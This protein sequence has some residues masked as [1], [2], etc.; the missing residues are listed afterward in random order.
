MVRDEI[1]ASRHLLEALRVDAVVA[2]QRLDVRDARLLVPGR[3][4]RVEPDQ[5]AEKV[6]GVDH[7]F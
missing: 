3:V 2:E 6:D 7:R 1:R 5:L 4:R